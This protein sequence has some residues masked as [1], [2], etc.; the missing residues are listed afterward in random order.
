M[1]TEPKIA[2]G[3][4]AHGKAICMSMQSTVGL[5]FEFEQAQHAAAQIEH[6]IGAIRISA[7]HVYLPLRCEATKT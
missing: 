4:T 3:G 7:F 1:P 2:G 5:A 6:R